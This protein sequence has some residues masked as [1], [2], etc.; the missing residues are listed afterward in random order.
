MTTIDGNSRDFST[1]KGKYCLVVNV[2]SACGFTPQ[3]EGLEALFRE[4]QHRFSVLAFPCNQFGHQEPGSEDEIKA[5]CSVNYDVTFDLFSKIDVN[6]DSRAPLY[7]W[8]CRD[9]FTNTPQ[10]ISW[11]FEKFLIDPEGNVVH[12]FTPDTSPAQ[13]ETI[14][15]GLL[16]PCQSA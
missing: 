16:E 14:L 4:Y 15:L 10:K 2:A 12:H 13:I 11:N 5:F 1:Y 8:L 3:Y 9:E 6:G 7:S